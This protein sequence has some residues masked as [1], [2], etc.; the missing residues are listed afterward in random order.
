MCLKFMQ[1][2]RKSLTEHM[3]ETLSTNI[4][5]VR[6]SVCGLLRV[7]KTAQNQFEVGV[8]GTTWCVVRNRYFITA[9][10]VL[11]NGQARNPNDNFLILR[12]PGNGPRL[13]RVPVV[14]FVLEDQRCD[15]VILEIDEQVGASLGIN[16][17]NIYTGLVPDGT[18]VLTY[19]YP[20]PKVTNARVNTQG[21]LTG[22]RTMLLSHANE[23]I[24]ASQY[25]F[26]AYHMY[27]L[28]VDWHHGE[29]GGP[30]LIFDPPRVIAIM[31]HYRNIET[32]HG[33]VAGPHRGI[34][35][36]AI[37]SHIANLGR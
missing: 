10:H 29:S 34:A 1:V 7:R 24:V 30:I 19:G 26:N 3:P 4:E 32:P 11:N 28:N 12:A 35:I 20:A 17:L 33:T 21:K 36:S 8:V 22:V 27:E 25:E 23:G 6:D 5:Q 16:A 37:S 2:W 14:A 13:E 31:Q 15:Y 9:Y 18:R